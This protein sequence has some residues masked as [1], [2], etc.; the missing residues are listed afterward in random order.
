MGRLLKRL[1]RKRSNRTCTFAQTAAKKVVNWA[2]PLSILILE[3]L[4]I[5]PPRKGTIG[6]KALRRRLS[7]W[8]HEQIVH[9]ARCRAEERSMAASVKQRIAFGERAR[10]NV[11][12]IGSGFGSEGKRPELT[13]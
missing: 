4:H 6:G 3:D 2:P 11:R 1:G 8:Q 9:Y 12:R 10:Q 13:E 7:Q 5:P